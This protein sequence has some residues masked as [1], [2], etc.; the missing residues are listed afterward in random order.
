MIKHSGPYLIHCNAGID[1]TGFVAAII[2]AW[3]G[4]E[5]D[6]IVYDYLL[7]YGKTFAD[8]ANTELHK[9]TGEIIINQ[10]NTIIDGKI[11]DIDYLHSNIEKYLLNEI[12]L[13]T[14]E[15]N[16]LLTKLISLIYFLK[17]SLSSWQPPDT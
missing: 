16:M 8:E 2:K 6:E 9:T 5:I 1:R 17:N 15:I 12:G 4:A 3:F 13:T 14:E 10:L 11:G 7:S